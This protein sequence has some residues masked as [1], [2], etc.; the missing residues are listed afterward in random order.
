MKHYAKL[1]INR[2]RTVDYRVE[3]NFN[4]KHEIN[5]IE[6]KLKN[7]KKDLEENENEIFN[8]LRIDYSTEEITEAK[9]KFYGE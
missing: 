4:L 9:K 8:L 6:N 7:L 3:E 2:N 5:R 1:L